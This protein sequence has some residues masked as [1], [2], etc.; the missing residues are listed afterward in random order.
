VSAV[1]RP[2]LTP[3]S[4]SHEDTGPASGFDTSPALDARFGADDAGVLR[5]ADDARRGLAGVRWLALRRRA[6][7]ALALLGCVGLFA[8]LRGLASTP[9]IDIEWRETSTGQIELLSATD[10]VLRLR[11]GQYLRGLESA[12]GEMLPAEMLATRPSLRW[13]V[14]DAVPEVLR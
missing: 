6:L 4:G 13:I 10:P 2:G 14:S 5:G 9:Y 11:A 7:T 1:P 8:L 3:P 12:S